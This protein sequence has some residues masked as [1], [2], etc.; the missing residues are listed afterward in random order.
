MCKFQKNLKEPSLHCLK[1]VHHKNLLCSKSLK[2]LL[3]SIKKL[4]GLFI[5]IFHNK[6]SKFRKTKNREIKK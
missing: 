1:F 3:K 2:E 6:A 5:S 4:N